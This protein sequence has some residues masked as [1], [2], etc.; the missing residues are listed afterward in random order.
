MRTALVE[1]LVDMADADDRIFLLTADLGFSVVERFAQRHP[2]RF[3]NVGV[4]EQNMIG[5]AT[6]LAQ[7]GFVPFCYS[8]ATF[9]SMR[10]Y[11]QVRNGPVLHRLPVSDD[12]GA[13]LRQRQGVLGRTLDIVLAYE[14]HDLERLARS[15]LEPTTV[16]IAYRHALAWVGRITRG[17]EAAPA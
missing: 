17:L 16:V 4:A 3:I 10:G 5:I 15:R 11:E 2:R 13:A 8:I 12:I 14:R 6:G 7:L 9:A 1:T